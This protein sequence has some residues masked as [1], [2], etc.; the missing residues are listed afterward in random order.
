MLALALSGRAFDAHFD[1]R[2]DHLRFYT[3]RTLARVLQGGGFEEI[4]I[5]GAAGI[6]GARRV[7]LASARR[8]RA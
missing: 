3:R 5:R 4:R 6:P 1:P 8:P 7:L 2:A